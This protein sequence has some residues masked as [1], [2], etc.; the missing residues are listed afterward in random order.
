[1]LEGKCP[2]CGARYYGW[3]LTMPRHQ[4][5]D[6]CG[7]GLEITEDGRAVGKGYSPFE[8]E[9]YVVKAPPGSTTAQEKDEEKEKEKDRKQDKGKSK[10]KDKNSILN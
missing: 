6:K 2:K 7:V 4:M 1:M 5:C 9:E 10:N 3:A 8:A